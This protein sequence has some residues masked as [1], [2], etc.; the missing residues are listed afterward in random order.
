VVELG[1]VVVGEVEEDHKEAVIQVVVGTG[2][3][4][5]IGQILVGEASQGRPK[6]IR[7]HVSFTLNL[8]IGE[9]IVRN[10]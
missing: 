3:V 1:K 9:L 6:S 7:L 5:L 8:A 10:I 2:L 4:V